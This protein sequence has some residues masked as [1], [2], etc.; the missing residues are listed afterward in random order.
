M[1]IGCV[2][3]YHDMWSSHTHILT[4]LTNHSGLKKKDPK[5]WKDEMQKAFDKMHALM[6]ADALT[7]YPDHNKWFDI[8]TD[9]SD[10]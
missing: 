2:N 1:F 6:V 9:A 10:L 3:Y 4:P 5:S 8:Y 7:A